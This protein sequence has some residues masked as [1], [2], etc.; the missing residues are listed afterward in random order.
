MKK[1]VMLLGVVCISFSLGWVWRSLVAMSDRSASD[2]RTRICLEGCFDL[3]ERLSSLR[4]EELVSQ[5]MKDA[6]NV[7]GQALTD[8]D[9]HTNGA[10]EFFIKW[11]RVLQ[12]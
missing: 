4:D 10:S 8:K 1:T 7:L 12:D 2:M 11:E 6:R 5:Y 9:I 3:Y